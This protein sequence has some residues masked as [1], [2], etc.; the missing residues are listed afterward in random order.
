M[1]TFFLTIILCL[2]AGSVSFAQSYE[3]R[4][5]RYTDPDAD[6]FIGTWKH[7]STRHQSKCMVNYFSL[8]HASTIFGKYPCSKR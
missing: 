4:I 5:K 8:T 6:K 3:D 7:E 2:A 1:R